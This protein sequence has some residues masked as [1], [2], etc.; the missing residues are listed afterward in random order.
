MENFEAVVSSVKDQLSDS[1]DLIIFY[2]K[3]TDFLTD[4]DETQ[5]RIPGAVS[6]SN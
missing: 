2:Q 3:L 4:L 6:F 1:G 5:N